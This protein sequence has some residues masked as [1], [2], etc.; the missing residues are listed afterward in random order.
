MAVEEVRVWRPPREEGILL[1]TGETTSYSIEPRGDYIFGVVTGEAMRARRGR[2][3]Y[4]VRPGEL[5]AWDP[6]EPHRGTTARDQPWSSRLMIVEG[7]DLARLAADD[8]EEGL[9]NIRFP[10]PVLRDPRLVA[11]FLRL[12][13]SFERPGMVLEQDE[14]LTE[15]LHSV[16]RRGAAVPP[17]RHPRDARDDRALRLAGEYLVEHGMENVRLDQL[18]AASGVGKFHLVRLFRERTGLPPHAFQLAHRL[19]AARRLLEAG[20][21]V[22]GAA[23]ST[24]FSDQ[25]HLH[26]HF[27]RSIGMTPG[28]YRR[29]TSR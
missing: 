16:T 12:H 24:G 28:A 29:R 17:S 6:G 23:A 1:M 2:E 4:L 3:T 13:A 22:A 15:W 8:D 19:R 5:V 9:V 20:E 27:R 7:G 26:R 14:R 21:S 18:A 25:S 11:G 10:S